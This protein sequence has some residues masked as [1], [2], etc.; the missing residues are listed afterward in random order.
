[1]DLYNSLGGVSKESPLFCDFVRKPQ[2]SPSVKVL[3][4]IINFFNHLI[5]SKKKVISL[6]QN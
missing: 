1:M 4:S 6:S 2:N 3:I 5:K